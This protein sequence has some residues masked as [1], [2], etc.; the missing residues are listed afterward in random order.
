LK[1]WYQVEGEESMKQIPYSTG[2]IQIG[3]NYTPP[4]QN[5]MSQEDMFWQSVILGERQYV[6]T[7]LRMS[8]AMGVAAL[9]AMLVLWMTL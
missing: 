7:I 1:P 8:Y 5:A 2:K 6:I 4:K 3:I 9:V